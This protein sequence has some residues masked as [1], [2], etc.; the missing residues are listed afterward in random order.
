LK[1]NEFKVTK[2]FNATTPIS[3]AERRFIPGEI[4]VC[5][6]KQQGST[7][8]LQ[9][10]GAFFLVDRSVFEACCTRI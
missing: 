6:P 3:G 9:L 8:T 5:D 4:V 7:L 10:G 1:K 2:A